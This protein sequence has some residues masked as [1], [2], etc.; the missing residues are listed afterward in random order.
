[1]TSLR[2]AEI[3]KRVPEGFEDDPEA[4]LNETDLENE[5]G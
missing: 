1:M 3:R 5:P 2:E 4:D